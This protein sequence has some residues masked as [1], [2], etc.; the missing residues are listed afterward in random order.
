MEV[1]ELYYNERIVYIRE[2]LNLSQ[3]QVA[4]HLG[5][6]QQQYARYEKGINEIPVHHLKNLCLYFGVTSD[7]ILDIPKG[8]K[9]PD[10]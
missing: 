1:N 8:L 2:S 6:K 5:I 9:Y 10:R 7:Y 3:K 4:E